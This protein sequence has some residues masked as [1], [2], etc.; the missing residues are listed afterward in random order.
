MSLIDINKTLIKTFDDLNDIVDESKTNNTSGEI[1]GIKGT[2]AL[3]YLGLKGPKGYVSAFNWF[4]KGKRN[5]IIKENNEAPGS[6]MISNNEVNRALGLLWKTYSKKDRSQYEEL[7]RVDKMRYLKEL[8]EI[9]SKQNI[10]IIPRINIPSEYLNTHDLKL[11]DDYDKSKSSVHSNN[12]K[13]ILDVTSS[14]TVWKGEINR[15]ISAYNH[16]AHQ[17][18]QY[19]SVLGDPHLDSKIGIYL[20]MRWK[21]L[22]ED[23]RNLYRQ[24]G[25]NVI[26]KLLL[27][28]FLIILF[29]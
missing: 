8:D 21:S 6:V 16:F 28:F 12:S 3:K 22:D 27:I 5:D 11:L 13:V 15:P 19:I 4:V 24:L 7:A 20:G 26:I 25:I 14:A 2:K 10:K 29:N 23:E 1:I 18:K 9:N 17:E